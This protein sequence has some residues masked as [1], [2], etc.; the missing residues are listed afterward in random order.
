[1]KLKIKKITKPMQAR[2]FGLLIVER[3]IEETKAIVRNRK[4]EGR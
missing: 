2:G 4:L 1:M 3:S